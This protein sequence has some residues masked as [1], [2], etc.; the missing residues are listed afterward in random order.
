MAEGQVRRRRSG[1]RGWRGVRLAL[2]ALLA[3]AG[4]A[5]ALL[6]FAP[7]FTDWNRHRAAVAAVVSA[8]LGRPV[9]ITGPITLSLLPQTEL[10]AGGVIIRDAG[11]GVGIRARAIRLRV[12]LGPL[13]AGR[14]VMRTLFLSHP[15]VTLPWPLPPNGIA[16]ISPAWLSDLSARIE[17]GTLIIGGTAVHRVNARLASGGGAGA[18]SASGTARF[19]G[20]GWSFILTLAEPD[21]KGAA[22]LSVRVNERAAKSGGKAPI[23]LG[24]SGA[25]SPAGGVSGEVALQG[26]DLAALLPA[27]AVSFDLRGPLHASARE[28]V[29]PQAALALG[30][31]PG[32]GRLRLTIAPTL[33]LHLAVHLSRLV[34][35][36]WLAVW[37]AATPKPAAVPITLTFAVDRALLP[38][39]TL[40]DLRGTLRWGGHAL[41]VTALSA[42]LPGGATAGFRGR[43]RAGPRGGGRVRLAAPD[44]A[45]TAAWIASAA[46]GHWPATPPGV[47]GPA[48][49]RARV[50]AAPGRIALS[51]L[52][53]RIARSRLS[54]AATLHL[55]PRPLLAAGLALDRLTLDPWL[56]ASPAALGQALG[57][58]GLDLQVTVQR[59][60]L[61]GWRIDHLLIDVASG[62][63]RVVV[64]RADAAIGG[65]HA[66]AAATWTPSAAPPAPGSAKPGAVKPGAVKPGAVKPGAA[67]APRLAAGR[68]SRARLELSAPD[69]MALARL[70][71][72]L[73]AHAP[74]LLRGPF[75]LSATASGT[76]R[77]LAISLA[78]RLGELRLTAAPVL[79]L[80]LRH[81][82]GPF[83]LHYPGAA[84]LLAGLGLANPALWVGPGSLSL[85]ADVGLSPGRIDAHSF[86][87]T[88]G[89]R[90]ASGDLVVT[91]G[92]AGPGLAGHL[93]LDA[94]AL[95]RPTAAWRLPLS[96]LHLWHGDLG[97]R[98]AA[99]SLWG[100]ARFTGLTGS[101]VQSK[102]R[103][104]ADLTAA[105]FAGG[106][107]SGR[108]SLAVGQGLPRLSLVAT[109][110][111]VHIAR[112]VL[113]APLDILA[114]IASGHLA[115]RASGYSLPAF[116]ASLAGTLDVEVLHG[117]LGGFDLARL[118]AAVAAKA[119]A[120]PLT[121]AFGAGETGF[122]RLALA[123]TVAEG[124]VT[125]TAGRLSG[126]AGGAEIGGT[127]GLL[128]PR[129]DL[130]LRL[131][132]ALPA[133]PTLGLAVSGPLARPQ[134][135]PDLGPAIAWRLAHP[136]PP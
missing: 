71:P 75:T 22:G 64:R 125:L 33:G 93:S 94:I 119:G 78:A 98:L 70:F 38:A 18:L 55:T 106:T 113:R 30:G 91:L 29:A 49:L 1:R 42:G 105:R 114:G 101:L 111:R 132:P 21:A 28:V 130:R 3:L 39:G 35:A 129:F 131:T 95:P 41:T 11:D 27:P 26:G 110:S 109:L 82:R 5:L 13:L 56:A 73:A 53:G 116:A 97:L 68:L 58:L 6:W 127:V 69:T 83:T 74:G 23:G 25:V 57:G 121:A 10:H 60:D 123:G 36:P 80:A 14:V 118:A 15:V 124:A 92:S 67:A 20:R 31:S 32:H 86:A 4:V 66:L 44:L 43:L 46:G 50:S 134:F 37:R 77:A 104:E 19:G 99:L 76:P 8:A 51:G 54:G 128:P 102:G 90:H 108:A 133:P 87:L 136:A 100:R 2:V 45:A 112:P 24:F 88:A 47:L 63:G 96:W 17:D 65:V 85:I 48:D 52:S 59:L 89:A 16:A 72:T 9:R 107:V 12:A 7:R 62:G 126:S 122:A 135:V 84:R 81:G 61:R 79:D 103:L 117:R 40:Q 120:P 115:V 34:L